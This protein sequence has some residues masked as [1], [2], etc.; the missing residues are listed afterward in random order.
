M[1][2]CIDDLEWLSAHVLDDSLSA[3]AYESLG[4]S[5]RAVLKKCLA[6][7]YAVWGEPSRREC[8]ERAYRHGFSLVETEAPVPYAVVLCDAQYAWPAAFAA[9]IMP[10]LL[11]G[12]EHVFPVFIPASGAESAPP[13][14]PLL[15][16]LELA[17]VEQAYSASV[18]S[19]VTF[20]DDLRRLSGVG[21]LVVLGADP[22]LEAAALWAFRNAVPLYTPPAIPV[23]QNAQNRPA[24]P[25]FMDE[26]DGATQHAAAPVLRLDAE[27]EQVWFWPDLPPAWFRS[28]HMALAGSPE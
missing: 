2:A 25:V 12:V 20:L 14:S 1:N 16:V 23:F 22:A 11:A 10:A 15:A 24:V 13:L 26:A 3:S 5:G 6:R 17:G 4:D 18:A 27:H 19:S 28:R 8:R 9:A 21:R 7:Q